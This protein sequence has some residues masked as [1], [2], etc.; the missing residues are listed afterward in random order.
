MFVVRAHEREARKQE[1][2]R[3]EESRKEGKKHLE[4][5]RQQVVDVL[6]CG[7]A[8]P[9]VGKR[10]QQFRCPAKREIAPASKDTLSSFAGGE[11][12]RHKAT[13]LRRVCTAL[14]VHS[15]QDRVDQA[16]AH[17]LHVGRQALQGQNHKQARSTTRK[18][19]KHARAKQATH[20]QSRQARTAKGSSPAAKSLARSLSVS[21]FA[22]LVARALSSWPPR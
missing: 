8:Q 11:R 14:A 5:G 19:G 12:I 3:K 17:I 21:S 7:V 18:A 22:M 13:R 1:E 10:A 4:E 16:H 15:K 9:V 6:E 20:A 2:S